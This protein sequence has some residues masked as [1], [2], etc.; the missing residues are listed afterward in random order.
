VKKLTKCCYFLLT[1]LATVGYGDYFAVNQIEKIVC[2]IIMVMG[3]AF[4]S[5]IMSNFVDIL[6]NYDIKMGNID[7]SSDLQIWLTSLSTKAYFFLT[8]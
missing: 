1:T 8:K 3:I 6:V 2:I 4:F 5:Y 7:R